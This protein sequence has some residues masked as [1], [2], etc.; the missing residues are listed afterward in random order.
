MTLSLFSSFD[1]PFCNSD[2]AYITPKYWNG[3]RVVFCGQCD[4]YFSEIDGDTIVWVEH[5]GDDVPDAFDHPVDSRY[6]EDDPPFHHDD[7]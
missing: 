1:C 6:F 5:G 3:Q 7:E 4:S 2:D